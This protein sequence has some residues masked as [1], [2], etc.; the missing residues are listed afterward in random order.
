MY[1]QERVIEDD[2]ILHKKKHQQRKWDHTKD[3]IDIKN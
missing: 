2:E 1:Q 3:K